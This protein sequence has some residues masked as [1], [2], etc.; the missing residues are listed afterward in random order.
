MSQYAPLFYQIPNYKNSINEEFEKTDNGIL[1]I[2]QVSIPGYQYFRVKN[3]DSARPCVIICPGGGYHILAAGHE[4][5]AVANY[6]NSIG[7]NAILLKYRI[8]N[9]EHQFDKTIA[10]LQDLQ[11]AIYLAR[12]NGKKW[13]IDE[14]KIGVMGF[15][16]GGHLAASLST[17]YNDVKINNPEGISLRPNFQVLIYPV[18]TFRTFGHMGSMKNLVGAYANEEKIHYFSNEENIDKNTPMAFI[19]HAKDDETV[20]VKNAEIYHQNL[21]NVNVN[22]TLFIMEKG[23]HGFGLN[24]SK[25][26]IQWPPL[27]NEWLRKNSILP[28]LFLAHNR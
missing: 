19:V 26:E 7:V 27:L 20:P 4:G 3:D 5:I 23:G 28:N 1:R 10:P 22:S 24:N 12:M 16:A 25:T 21:V 15:S 18:I 6:F 17:H 8:P 11:Q 2:N 13:G 14:N 9:E